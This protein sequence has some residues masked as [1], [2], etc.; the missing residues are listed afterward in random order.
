MTEED[1]HDLLTPKFWI[2]VCYPCGRMLT[3]IYWHRYY[4]GRIYSGGSKSAQNVAELY[5]LI[6]NSHDVNDKFG[7]VCIFV[8]IS[9]CVRNVVQNA[10]VDHIVAP[11]VL[12]TF[13]FVLNVF[14]NSFNILM[15][16]KLLCTAACLPHDLSSCLLIVYNFAPYVYIIWLIF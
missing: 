2:A 14:S 6:T 10:T 7:I 1:N 8:T 16:A 9:I 3:N 13:N 5:H 12:G 4:C 15:L 11:S